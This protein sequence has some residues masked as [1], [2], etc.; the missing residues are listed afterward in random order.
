MYTSNNSDKESSQDIRSWPKITTHRR[1][2]GHKN[3]KAKV[4]TKVSGLI[5]TAGM[6]IILD[7]KVSM[8]TMF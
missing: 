6:R 1:N 8:V 2:R 5:K 3:I 4:N 7:H